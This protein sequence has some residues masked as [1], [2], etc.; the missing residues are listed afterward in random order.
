MK[1]SILPLLFIFL[2]AS[3]TNSSPDDLIDNQPI[4]D[5]VTYD[6]HIANIMQSQ[7]VSCH[8]ANFPSGNLSLENYQ[9]V[10]ASTEN[11]SL[12][13]RITRTAGDP[14]IMPQNGQLPSSSIDLIIQWQTDGYL[15]N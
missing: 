6:A 9:E 11:G 14:L 10:R 7:C 2:L 1:T 3:C 4:T 5:P 13:D 8:N 15:E 12:I